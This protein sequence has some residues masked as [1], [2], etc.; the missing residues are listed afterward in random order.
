MNK[1]P[2]PLG[3]IT[4]HHRSSFT[5][6]LKG[7]TLVPFCT[8]YARYRGVNNHAYHEAKGFW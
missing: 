3:T 8:D 2:R 6:L 1:T 5:S 7:C 4:T